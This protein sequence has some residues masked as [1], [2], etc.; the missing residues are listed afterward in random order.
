MT[1][2]RLLVANLDCEADFAALVGRPRMTLSAAARQA[3]A[4]AGLLMRTFA[5]DGDR[6]W[7][8]APVDSARLGG[9]EGLP[10]VEL[11]DDPGDV[12]APSAVL[13]W[14][15]TARTAA[16][17]RSCAEP[18]GADGLDGPLHEVL[19]RL[20]VPSPAV[21]ARVAD[22]ALAAALAGELGVA[23]PGARRVQTLAEARALAD[24]DGPWVLKAAYAAA[25]RWR[26]I[27]RPPAPFPAARVTRLLA[28]HGP[29]HFEPW[30]DRTLDVG[31][32]GLVGRAAWRPLGV[33]RL[34]A[35]RDGRF[36]GI[37]VVPGDDVGLEPGERRLLDT[38][39]AAVAEA[40]RRAGYT[41]PF[42]VDA[43][44]HRR[45]D[46]TE[47]FHPL[48]EINPRLT[49]GF[50]ARSLGERRGGGGCSLRLG[51]RSGDGVS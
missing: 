8:C 43:W 7:L 21:V 49:F 36:A 18:A 20:P 38:T 47:A 28:R 32:L 11:V 37:D 34:H 12:P 3:A 4:E 19:W 46:G 24:V 31:A 2:P 9:I 22:R 15:E 26:V 17:R 41:G 44:R 1:T 25:G 39:M 42:G 16:L 5:R 50:V 29:L 14:G 6:L 13:A 51:G 23:L 35:D 10:H 30:C 40:L 48:G 45:G 33:H 27:H